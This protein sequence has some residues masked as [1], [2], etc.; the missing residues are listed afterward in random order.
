MPKRSEREEYFD[1]FNENNPY[2]NKTAHYLYKSLRWGNAAKDAFEIDGPEDMATL[3]DLAQIKFEDSWL[4]QKY[5]ES[6]APFLAV[7]KHS[8][9]LYIVE[10]DET[11]APINIPSSGYKFVGLA[12]RIDYYSDKGN[13]K[14]YYYHNHEK[15]YPEVFIHKTKN[16]MI[17]KPS[18]LENG[19]PSFIVREEGIIG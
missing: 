15:P 18:I 11:F 2:K 8:N 6:D 10:K 4:N 12:K 16:I 13:E 1:K 9:Y 3:G 14:A 5:H 7:G 19:M 17:I